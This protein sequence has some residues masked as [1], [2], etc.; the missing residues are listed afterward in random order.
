MKHV[1]NRESCTRS[2][3]KFDHGTVELSLPNETRKLEQGHYISIRQGLNTWSDMT[4]C[5]RKMHR[6]TDEKASSAISFKKAD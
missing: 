3:E 2:E 1:T 6:N 5:K 4:I